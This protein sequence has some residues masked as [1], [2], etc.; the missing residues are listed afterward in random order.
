MNRKITKKARRT[1]R[2][3]ALRGTQKWKN[4]SPEMRTGKRMRPSHG[5][6][7]NG[8]SPNTKPRKYKTKRNRGEPKA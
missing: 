2:K 6:G 1:D 7:F 4:T 8:K 5:W 3:N